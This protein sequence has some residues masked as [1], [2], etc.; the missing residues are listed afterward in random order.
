MGK[1]GRGGSSARSLVDFV[2]GVLGL[3]SS[4]KAVP[5]SL[6]EAN[7]VCRALARSDKN[8]ILALGIASGCGTER[9]AHRWRSG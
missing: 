9:E 7:T 1:G 8:K 2:A 5:A 3:Q 6:T 4:V